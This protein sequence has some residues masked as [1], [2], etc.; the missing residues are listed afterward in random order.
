M[1][2]EVVHDDPDE[3]EKAAANVQG[4]PTASPIDIT[5]ATAALLQK[6]GDIEEAIKK[7]RAVAVV[8]EGSDKELAARAWFSVGYLYQEHKKA[9]LETV[10]DTYN[11]A[12]R[13]KPDSTTYNNRGTAKNDL[14][15]HKEAI[16]DYDDAIRLKPN[17]AEAYYNRGNAKDILRRHEEAIADYD[18][19]IRLK[20]DLIAAYNN[21][22]GAKNELGR[23]EEAI[24]DCD[25]AIRLKPDLAEAYFIRGNAKIGLG[26]REE[27]IADYDDAIRLK[28]DL[29]AAY[30]NRGN[31]NSYLNRI[32]DARRD[33]ETTIDLARNA[34]DEDLMILA[35]RALSE[36]P[37]EQNL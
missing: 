29:I 33:F 37:D 18:D 16:V 6:R 7:W 30:N 9:D 4:D 11:I 22:G 17:Y 21:R 34:G 25:D 19:A 2:A 36:L 3:A 20:P 26:R 15:R 31:A 24:A 12:T 5:V 35:Q 13:L 8:S 27:A 28:P 14:G 23:H 32:D 1:T 10:I